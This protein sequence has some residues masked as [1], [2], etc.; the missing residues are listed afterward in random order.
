MRFFTKHLNSKNVQRLDTNETMISSNGGTT[1]ITGPILIQ[2]DGNGTTRIMQGYDAATD[3]FIY[4]LFNASGDQTIG[5]NSETGNATFTGDITGS[6][7]T[8]GLVRTAEEGEN[9][10]ELSGGSF[11]GI[12]DD[13]KTAGL[14]FEITPLG[15]TDIFL[16]H[17][18]VPVAMLEDEIDGYSLRGIPGNA[19]HL[20]IGGPLQSAGPGGP[21]VP[22]YLNGDV[23]FTGDVSFSYADSIAGLVTGTEG[24]HDHSGYTGYAG[25]DPHRHT[26]S[27]DGSHYHNIIIG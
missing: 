27:D 23:N 24:S 9:R 11:K 20:G 6:T 8:G 25:T 14:Y 5:M 1:K 19:L 12:T 2:K 26:I 15:V 4:A 13:E 16:Y 21:S 10:I 17:S 18:G 3:T 22:V 7:I